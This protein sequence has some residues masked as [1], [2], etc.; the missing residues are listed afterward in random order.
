V[1]QIEEATSTIKDNIVLRTSKWSEQKEAVG[2][3]KKSKPWAKA[4]G[5]RRCLQHLSQRSA[6]FVLDRLQTTI[7]NDFFCR[8]TADRDEAH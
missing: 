2:V 6:D 5:R 3:S 4:R 1:S 7:R 8:W